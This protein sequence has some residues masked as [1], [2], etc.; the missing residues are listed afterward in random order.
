MQ[1]LLQITSARGPLECC[2]VVAQLAQELVSNA[3]QLGLT[4]A[5]IEEEAGQEKGT[6]LSALI[7]I[8]GDECSTFATSWIGTVQWIAFSPFRSGYKRKNWFVGVDLITIPEIPKFREQDVRIETLKSSGPGGQHVNTTESAVRAIH[9]PTGL[10]T[11]AREERSQ[12]ANR[13]LA[14]RR[15]AILIARREQRQLV[16]VQKM[17]WNHHNDLVRGNPVRVYDHGKLRRFEF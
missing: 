16:E 1:I 14:L 3:T 17:K 2:W 6:L 13:K 15:L 10:T 7:H 9:I 4:A 5:A 12:T 8:E 11:I